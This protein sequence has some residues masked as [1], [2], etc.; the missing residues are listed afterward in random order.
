MMPTRFTR[1]SPKHTYPPKKPTTPTPTLTPTQIEDLRKRL[2]FLVKRGGNDGLLTNLDLNLLDAL[3]AVAEVGGMRAWNNGEELECWPKGT[4]ATII[5][6]CA[7]I[8]EI[9]E[10]NFPDTMRRDIAAAIRALSK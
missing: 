1:R 10:S 4:V 8:A 7:R 6:R 3:I 5:E 2:A 9:A